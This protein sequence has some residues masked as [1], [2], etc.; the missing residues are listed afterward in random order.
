MSENVAYLSKAQV[1]Q[2]AEAEQAPPRKRRGRPQA[3]KGEATDK[4]PARK[5]KAAAAVAV[6]TKEEQRVAA[7]LSRLTGKL[8]DYNQK[9]AGLRGQISNEYGIAVDAVQLHKAAYRLV[10]KLRQQIDNDEALK[11]ADFIRAFKLYARLL[12]IDKDTQD[13]FEDMDREV[14][15]QKKAAG[16]AY[17]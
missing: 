13:L 5:A 17:A 12:E 16:G 11:A 7:E 9:I 3:N 1:D 6:D 4:K 15:Q 2:S 10:Y 14:E 8:V